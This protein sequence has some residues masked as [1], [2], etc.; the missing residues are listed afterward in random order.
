MDGTVGPDLAETYRLAEEPVSKVQALSRRMMDVARDTPAS[1]QAVHLA[2]IMDP[3][4]RWVSRQGVTMTLEL[5][6]DVVVEGDPVGLTQVVENILRNAVE[7]LSG[8]GHIQVQ[9]RS[10]WNDQSAVTELTFDDSGGTP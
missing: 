5:D 6:H 2:S 1:R 8:D 10:S 7:A 3:L 4:H 9:S